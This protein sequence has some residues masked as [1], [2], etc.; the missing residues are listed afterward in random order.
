MPDAP[1]ARALTPTDASDHGD[2][3]HTSGELRESDA[4]QT[5][6]LKGWVDTRRNFGGLQFIDL[7]DRY[8]LTQLVFSPEIDADL[9]DLAEK[10]RGE[11]VISV[12]GEVRVRERKNPDMATGDVEVY[13][14]DLDVLA[15]SDTPPFVVSAGDP[16]STQAGD[17]LRLTYR[18]L[19]LR[20]PALQKNLLLRSK[21]YQSVRR[22]FADRDFV[23]VE[24]PVLMKSTPEGAR[25]YLVPSRVHP[26]QFYALPQS[27]QTYKQILMVAGMD[28]YVQITKCFR[29]EDLRADRQPE[30]TQIDVEMTFATE[31]GVYALVEGLIADVWRDTRGIEIETPFPHVTYAEAL[32]RYGSDKP[33]LRFGMEIADVS[34]AVEGSGFT[35][36][37]SI[38]D[39]GGAVVAIRVEGEGDRGRKPM[40]KLDKDVVRKQIGAGGLFYA[41]LP[42]DGSEFS[43]SVKDEVFGRDRMQAVI[44]AVGAE[45]GDLVLVLAG[46]QPTVFEQM[47][48]LRLHMAR[49]TGL[50]PEGADGPWRF[51]WVTDFPLLEY[52]EDDGRYYAMHHPFTSPAPEDMGKLDSAPGE[53]RARAYDLVL[54]GS[55]VGGGSIRIHRADVQR[56][57]F[58]LLGISDE[59]AERRFGFLLDA[60]RYGA[61]PH[62]GIALG[63]D[64]LVMLLTGATSLRDV[65]AF[66]KTQQATE[67]M[68]SAPAAVDPE[69]LA[70]LHIETTAAP[71]DVDTTQPLSA[72]PT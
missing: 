48:S 9:A 51:L 17:E 39:A 27:P 8:G 52:S 6:V 21:L 19:D 23:E 66:P 1:H 22:Y 62:G 38:L 40:D 26:G 20:K 61:P 11:D 16:K 54:N 37:D 46:P 36:F 34:G 67:L 70:E 2:R 18:Y 3:T 55:E 43:Q 60:L 71:P 31:E 45:A 14:S 53:V 7:R 35:V 28:R 72:D 5:V 69:Q 57:M 59:E 12:R 30:F 15:V 33:D 44:D 10:L 24:T 29:D 41:K 50:V 49:E 56:R 47:G 65:I 25:D 32:R 63:L 58:D 13:V 42:S 4:G 68:S 64:R